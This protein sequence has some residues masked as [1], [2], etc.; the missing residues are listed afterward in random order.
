MKHQKKKIG[1]RVHKEYVDIQV[2]NEF[3]ENGFVL[4]NL[5]KINYNDFLNGIKK[6]Y[7]QFS[8]SIPEYVIKDALDSYDHLHLSHRY[9]NTSFALL[10]F[11]PDFII[12]KKDMFNYLF[13]PK[14]IAE[15][16]INENRRDND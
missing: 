16:L 12:D 5:G 3:T 4:Y 13:L 15:K 14:R 9:I 2:L 11:R 8:N 7:G 1:I 10:Q 6:R